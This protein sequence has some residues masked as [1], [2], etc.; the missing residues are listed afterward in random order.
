MGQELHTDYTHPLN[1]GNASGKTPLPRYDDE[2]MMWCVHTRRVRFSVCY[3]IKCVW[4]TYLYIL[5][6]LAEPSEQRTRLTFDT[7][8]IAWTI[9]SPATWQHDNVCIHCETASF[10]RHY[11]PAGGGQSIW[12][13]LKYIR[14]SLCMLCVDRKTNHLPNHPLTN[15]LIQRIEFRQERKSS[16]WRPKTPDEPKHLSHSLSRSQ[17][18][19][20]RYALGR[21]Q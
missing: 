21:C 2:W 14:R 6:I 16:R 3:L 17:I 5:A 1:H 7:W 8:H 18:I 20:Y 4:Y 12:H 19:E 10:D 11:R 15:S 13:T 9:G